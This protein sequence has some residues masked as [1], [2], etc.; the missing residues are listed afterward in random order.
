MPRS[1]SAVDFILSEAAKEAN[2]NIASLASQ[3]IASISYT[4]FKTHK[5]KKVGNFAEPS[6]RKL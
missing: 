3:L 6:L 4:L 5:C 2:R 1:G